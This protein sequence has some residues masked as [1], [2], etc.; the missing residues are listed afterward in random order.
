MELLQQIT[1]KTFQLILKMADSPHRKFAKLP[2]IM[3]GT[4]CVGIIYC[5]CITIYFQ[6][7]DPQMVGNSG[8]YGNRGSEG[9]EITPIDYIWKYGVIHL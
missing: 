1:A 3:R 7:W 2:V 9:M 8:K 6:C 4:K 5:S